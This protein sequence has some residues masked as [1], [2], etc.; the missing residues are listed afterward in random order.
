MIHIQGL[1]KKYGKQDVLKNLNLTLDKGHSVALIGPNGCGKTTMLK[2]ILGLVVP[3]A[4]SI[5]IWDNEVIGK[6]EYRRLIGYMPQIGRYPGNLTVKQLIDMISD[7]GGHRKASDFDLIHAFDLERIYN[8]KMNALS[9]GMTQKVSACMA[10]IFNPEILILDEPTAGLDPV[11]SEI[12]MDKIRLETE[13][14]KLILITSHILSELD[15]IV[16]SV[17]FMQE[18]RIGFHKDIPALLAD[19]GQHTISQ[20]IVNVLK[21][22]KAYV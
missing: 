15:R 7:V 20:A 22:E 2:C 14:G 11:A 12:L 13:R 21:K 3:D 4:G 10:F 8:K 18:G 16:D 6:F 1:S 19:T 17:V 9:G 5:R